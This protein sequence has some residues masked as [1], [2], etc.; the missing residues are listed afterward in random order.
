MKIGASYY[1]EVLPESDWDKDLKTGKEVG[2][3][4]LRCGEFAWSSLFTPEG[5]PTL[6]WVGRF[7]DTA[8]VNGYEVIWCTPSA[9]PP[10][11]LFER[12]PD[13]H[14]T[15]CEGVKMPVGIRRN[16]CPSHAGYLDLC[17][18]TAQSLAKE[19]GA[20]PAVRGW[21]VDNE[22]AG[23]GFTC[24]CDRCGAAFQK[25]LEQR[26]GTLEQLNTAWQTNVWSQSYTRWE[27]IPV[28]R[29]FKPAHTPALK[30]AWR[31]F[32]SDC[33]LNFYR[34]QA[35][36][37]RGAG[38]RDVTTNFYN[39]TW[40][41]PFDRWKW[42]PHLDAMGLSNYHDEELVSN[43]FELAILQGPQ[44]G[45]KPVWVLEQKAGQ[46]ASQNLLPDDLGRIERHIAICAEGGAESG[47]YW[48]LRQHAAGC[49]MEHGAVLRHDGRATRIARAIGAAIKGSAARTAKFASSERLLVFS[50]NQFWANETRPQMGGAYDCRVETE[51]NW[52][53]AAQQLFGKIRIGNFDH[54]SSDHSLILAPFFQLNEPGAE[55]VFKAALERGSTLITTVDFLRLDNENNV[56][57]LA[58]LGSVRHWIET[59]DLELMQLKAGTTVKGEI[60]GTAVTGSTF[61]AVPENPGVDTSSWKK[62]GHG[63]C[64]GYE[65]PLALE[66]KVGSGRLI[67][68]L[69][70]LDLAGVEALLRNLPGSTIP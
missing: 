60:D 2:L 53:A 22:I 8:A 21:Q 51:K 65:G 39:L 67:V 50:F 54:V 32:R 40:D 66:F 7:L 13:L 46:Q 64:E 16:Y 69:T 56:R 1:P 52:F 47:S 28:P 25:W 70:A 18:E 68:A 58:P 29:S 10:P 36:A 27:Q 30:F 15:T 6:Q 42:R 19:I 48:H 35:D 63:H 62:I 20:H 33:W 55:E 4:V 12:W 5:K 37:L 11:Y 57:R 31:R 44:P 23:D 49:E 14:A 34:R 41:L 17:A 9:T 43:A 61:W 38:A 45:E 59:P 26:Y 24:W 3:S